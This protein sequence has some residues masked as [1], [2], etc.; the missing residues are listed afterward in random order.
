MDPFKENIACGLLNTCAKV[1]YALAATV[2]MFFI[3]NSFSNDLVK[4]VY[5]SRTASMGQAFA[6]AIIL[7][8]LLVR[9][10]MYEPPQL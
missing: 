10:K 2:P 8:F 5:G 7:V 1:V 9:K 3:L 6:T 4:L